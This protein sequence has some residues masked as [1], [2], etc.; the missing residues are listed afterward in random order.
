[1]HLTRH[2]RSRW[3]LKG[4][5]GIGSN[6]SQPHTMATFPSQDPGL[7]SITVI[8]VGIWKPQTDHTMA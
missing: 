8:E 2:L 3:Q 5:A 6:V 7:Q 4:A 1:M